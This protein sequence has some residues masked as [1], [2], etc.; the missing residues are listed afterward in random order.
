M[1]GI[2]LATLVLASSSAFAAEY[3][4]RLVIYCKSLPAGQRVFSTQSVQVSGNSIL[5][6]EFDSSTQ[7]F[8][9]KKT[10]PTADCII[11]ADSLAQTVKRCCAIDELESGI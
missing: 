9:T 3:T 6:Q 10:I 8:E 11:E 4:G 5:L 2:I 1:K 7:Q